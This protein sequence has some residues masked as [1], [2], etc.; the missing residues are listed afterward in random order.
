MATKILHKRDANPY[1][2]PTLTEIDLGELA[3]N[4]YDGRLYTKKD[5]GVPAVVEIGGVEPTGLERITSSAGT[6][7]QFIGTD[8][9]Y[10]GPLGN[11]AIDFSISL[12]NNSGGPYGAMADNSQAFG[13]STIADGMAAHAEGIETKAT[14]EASHAEGVETEALGNVSHAE[15]YNTLAS[16]DFSHAEGFF[17]VAQNENM[18]VQ[19]QCNIGTSPNTIHET[20][21]GYLA[22]KYIQTVEFMLL[23]RQLLCMIPQDH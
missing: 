6:G 9:T 18:H 11:N 16:G 2:K 4:T 12:Q 5:D 21:V 17:T 20:G 8:I 1:S 13:Q 22:L 7:W 10:K 19:G 23:S 15:G 14:G 3:I